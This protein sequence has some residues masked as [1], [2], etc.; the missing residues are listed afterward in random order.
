[1]LSVIMAV[2]SDIASK[3][4]IGCCIS[5]GKP[6]YG[7]VLIFTA[8]VLALFLIRIESSDSVISTPISLSLAD[9]ASK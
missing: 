9:I 7:S 3:T 5:V 2:P 6:G 4:L 1:M 8:F